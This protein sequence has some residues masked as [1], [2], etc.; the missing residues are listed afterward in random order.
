MGLNQR[1]PSLPRIA[2][3]AGEPAG[4]GLDLCAM[5]ANHPLAASITVIADQNALLARAKLLGLTLHILQP[6]NPPLPHLGDGKLTVMHLPVAKTVVAGR[7]NAANSQYILQT[8]I[9]AAD[10][11]INGS[12]DATGFDAMVTAPVHKGIINDAGIAFTGHTEFLAEHTGAEQVVM[13]LIGGGMA[14]TFFVATGKAVGKSRYDKDGLDEANRIAS[15]AKKNGVDLVLP[16]KDV[17]VANGVEAPDSRR[18]IGLDEVG[19]EDMILDIGPE[20]LELFKNHLRGAKTIF[21]NGPLGVFEIKPFS[22]VLPKRFRF[23]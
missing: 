17:V 19:T 18:V 14:N 11:C 9:C 13:M 23:I 6:Q 10:G 20:S 4:I 15:D 7:L 12:F 8:L 22:N 1:L 2:I 3:T 21:W 16:D 5:L